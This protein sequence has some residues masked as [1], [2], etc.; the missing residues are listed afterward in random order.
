MTNQSNQMAVMQKDITDQVSNRISQLQDDGLALPKDYNPQNA[1]K[2]AWFKLQQTKDRSNRPALQV[3][4][5]SSIAN[6]L[7]D[8]VTQGLSPAKTQCYFIVYGNEVQLQRS[9]FGTIAAVKRLS[10]V[11]DIDAQVVHQGDEFAIGADELGRIKVTKFVPKF[12]NLD[13]PIKGAFA[14]I[15]L[16]DGRVDY[17]VMTQ[18]QIQ[19]SWGQSRQHN[20]QQK[21]GDEM[22]KR[23]VINRAAKMYINTSDDSDLLTGSINTVTA[24]E[25]EDEP[26]RK[27]VT[28]ETPKSTADKLVQG[29]KKEQAQIHEEEKQV[30]EKAPEQQPVKESEQDG[31]QEADGQTDIFD[32]IEDDQADEK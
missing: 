3:C 18:K 1:L 19:T 31:N 12:E 6:A 17:T 8:M 25:Y 29:F 10:S 4:T 7:L 24:N 32:Y 9:Y 22:A 28:P 16:A 14:F 21:F 27:D 13:K 20:V 23:T 26:E 11:K 30:A 15:E 2:A 5:R